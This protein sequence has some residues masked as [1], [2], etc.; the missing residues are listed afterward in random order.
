MPWRDAAKLIIDLC[1]ALVS[2]H[3]AG[4]VHRDI[5]P[6]NIML[7]AE[8]PKL[9]DFGLCRLP[10]QNLTQPGFLLGTVMY[11]SPEQ[12]SGLAATARSDIYSLGCV[13]FELLTGQTPFEADD[14]MAMVH[15]HAFA[16]PPKLSS[17]GQCSS[18]L[19]ELV[20][21][22]LSKNPKNRHASVTALMEE[23]SRI[24]ARKDEDFS[25]HNRK[26]PTSIT[27]SDHRKI[28]LT[29]AACTIVGLATYLAFTP[30]TC[31]LLWLYPTPMMQS[32]ALYGAKMMR[33]LHNYG[34]SYGL[35]FALAT[36]LNTQSSRPDQIASRMHIR[37]VL[38]E[39]NQ[40]IEKHLPSQL[41]QMLM[42]DCLSDLHGL[43]ETTPDVLIHWNNSNFENY[44]K[45]ISYADAGEQNKLQSNIGRMRD[46]SKLVWTRCFNS[47]GQLKN[48]PGLARAHFRAFEQMAAK[49][50]N[51]PSEKL[52]LLKMHWELMVY[53]G[54]YAG[55][56]RTAEALISQNPHSAESQYVLFELTGEHH[57]AGHF[58]EAFRAAKRVM[59][60]ESDLP[61][62]TF[63]KAA[64]ALD[65]AHMAHLLGN[66]KASIQYLRASDALS[67]RVHFPA[68]KKEFDER[69]RKVIKDISSHK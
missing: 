8:G 50:K 58:E 5:K 6:E 16:E 38:A 36:S 57:R 22:C 54:N 10:D 9:L 12:C 55:S 29:A 25:L 42:N 33:S 26:Q 19:E 52:K 1:E 66:D 67:T 63:L 7:S 48:P 32:V 64:G 46:I 11:V 61:E 3:S 18:D 27:R 65:C 47:V 69:R 31:L 13:F 17:F 24:V 62:S 30:I 15:Q 28:A 41:D 45:L 43:A 49:G 40:D 56:I 35:A 23:L 59:E 2:V 68:K 53:S 34:D 44:E 60:I 20:Q 37:R 51:F 4:I 14:P 21:R 39:L